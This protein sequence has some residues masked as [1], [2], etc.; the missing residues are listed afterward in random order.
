MRPG[1][2]SNLVH[3]SIVSFVPHLI[4]L[5][6]LAAHIIKSNASYSSKFNVDL[7]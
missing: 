2:H 5:D 6:W 4:R 7:A 3:G 1:P